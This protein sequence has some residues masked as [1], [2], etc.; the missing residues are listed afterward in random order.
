MTPTFKKPRAILFLLYEVS[1]V[2][3]TD[4]QGIGDSNSILI[5]FRTEGNFQQ[6]ARRKEFQDEED[7]YEWDDQGG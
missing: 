5:A 6:L 7:N 3:Y 1:F 2:L 4:Q